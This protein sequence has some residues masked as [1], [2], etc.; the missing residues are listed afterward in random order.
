VRD[1]S[2]DDDLGIEIEL[3]IDDGTEVV[4]KESTKI[5]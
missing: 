1:V 2:R 4:S 5:R 3:G